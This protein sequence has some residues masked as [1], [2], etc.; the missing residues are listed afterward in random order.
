MPEMTK[1]QLLDMVADLQHKVDTLQG[2]LD[3]SERKLAATEQKLS[4]V[5]KRQNEALIG[6]EI[7][8]AAMAVGIIPDGIPDIIGGAIRDGW[9]VN[10]RGEMELKD[11]KTG[12]VAFDVTPDTWAATQAKGRRRYLFH[13]GQNGQQPSG[14]GFGTAKN[15]WSKDTWNDT[16]QA[17]V[18]LAD[19]AKAEAMAKAA[20]S[21]VGALPPHLQT[22][23]PY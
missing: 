6:N 2:K 19:P 22:K 8:R 13:S 7:T 21:R 14:G 3:A 10:D 17:K 15:P 1:E 11:P 18:Y 5:T 20:G 23:T 16:E 9:T 4:D 12:A